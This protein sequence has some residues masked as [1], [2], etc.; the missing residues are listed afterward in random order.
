MTNQTPWP[1]FEPQP[2]AL[3]PPPP[4]DPYA[5][6]YAPHAALPQVFA[7]TGPG[8]VAGYPVQAPYGYTNAYPSLVP[9]RTNGL[10]VASMVLGIVGLMVS[11]FM[12][13]IPSILAAVFGHVS[14]HQIRHG[15]NRGGRGMAIAGLVTAYVALAGW[16][17]FLLVSLALTVAGV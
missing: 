1:P 15:S 12:L 13:G 8:A 2:A 16:L 9:M 5:Y 7:P 10:A 4:A 14:L 17:F 3:P 6:P 11:W